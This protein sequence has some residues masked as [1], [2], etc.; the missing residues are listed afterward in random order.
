[1]GK[2]VCFTGHRPQKLN[3]FNPLDN[4]DMLKELKNIIIDHIENKGVDTFISGMALGVDMWSARIVLGLKDKYPHIKLVCAIPCENQWSKWKYESTQ[5]WNN[6][7]TKA[8]KVHYVSTETFTAWCM[9]DRNKWMVDHSDY[10]IAVW[11][12]SKGGTENCVK[13]A[14]KQEKEILQ[15]NP[16][17]L[18]KKVLEV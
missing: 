14:I 11:D 6:I 15:L 13:Y 18:E 7:V 3:G 8:D 5:E 2:T 4:I 1:M 10:V 9:Q 17:T 12:G 16:K